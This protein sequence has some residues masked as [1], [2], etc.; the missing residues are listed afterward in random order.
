MA[1]RI[2]LTPLAQLD[3]QEIL[4]YWKIRN[5]SNVYSLK[6]NQ[7]FYEL[8]KEI[9]QYPKIGTI[10]IGLD[11]YSIVYNNYRIYYK[12]LDGTLIILRIWDT[13]RNPD[14]LIL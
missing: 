8:F 2:K 13:R 12:E 14:K 10:S 3:K 5:K 4:K 9:A 1:K 7:S 6:L 11:I